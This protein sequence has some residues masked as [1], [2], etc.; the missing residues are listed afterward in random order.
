MFCILGP[1][2]LEVRAEEVKP[3]AQHMGEGVLERHADQHH[4]T[5]IVVLEVDALGDLA[6]RDREEHGP[7][8]A[9]ARSPD[10][11]NGEK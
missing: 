1:P 4:A 3:R 5:A 6:P 7:L 9:V 8:P 10:E 11:W 2:H